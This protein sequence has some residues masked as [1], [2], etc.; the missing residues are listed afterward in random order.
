MKLGLTSAAFYGRME[1][2]EAAEF[3]P[4]LG[5]DTCEVFLESFSEYTADFGRIVREKLGALPCASVHPKGTQF[6]PDLFGQSE[7]QRA[8]AFALASGVMDAGRALGASYY[9]FHGPVSC[10]G[11]ITLEKIHALEAHFARLQQEAQA[12]GMELLWEN[13]SYGAVNC[14]DDYRY[15]RER[16]PEL[17]FVL[18]LK[19]AWR[20]GADPLD[21][22]HELGGAVRHVHLLDRADNGAICLPGQGAYDLDRFVRTLHDQGYTGALIIEPYAYQTTDMEALRRSIGFMQELLVKVGE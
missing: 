20:V 4:S 21:F 18:D 6:E 12:H 19:Q 15:I 3:L 2:D 5:L 17:H 22:L 16:L 9:V 8:D 10:L 14:I 13:V 11:R 7:R 1:T